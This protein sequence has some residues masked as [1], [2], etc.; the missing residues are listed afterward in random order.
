LQINVDKQI[1]KN[2]HTITLKQLPNA[3]IY[4]NAS[5]DYRVSMCNKQILPN[6]TIPFKVCGYLVVVF[7][8]SPN[9]L[10]ATLSAE[11]MQNY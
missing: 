2:M 8:A 11:S 1:F 9:G 4:I 5:Y 3:L 7:V 6:H 10:E